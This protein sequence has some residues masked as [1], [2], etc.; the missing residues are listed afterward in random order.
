M[1]NIIS[2]KSHLIE[3]NK[4][5]NKFNY[6]NH[7]FSEIYKIFTNLK[8]NIFIIF[9]IYFI[10]FLIINKFLFKKGKFKYSMGFATIFTIISFS[11]YYYYYII[12]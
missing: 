10:I 11:F 12:L 4:L 3:A 7:D 9:I 8:L 5:L 2:Q 6:R 1:N